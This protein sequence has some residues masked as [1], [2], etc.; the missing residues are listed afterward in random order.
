MVC[1]YDVV[2]I[3]TQAEFIPQLKQRA[4]FHM[5]CKYR[6]SRSIGTG[7]PFKREQVYEAHT[8]L[9]TEDRQEY[10]LP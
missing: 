8:L 7:I 2:A 5:S 10:V 1:F 6:R 4:F 3:A 9:L